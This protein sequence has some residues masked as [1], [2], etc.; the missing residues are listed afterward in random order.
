MRS[1][2]EFTRI[3]C[4]KIRAEVDESIANTIF[5]SVRDVDREI[6]FL[7]AIHNYPRIHVV[8]RSVNSVL[9]PEVRHSNIS[10]III[11]NDLSYMD[12]HYSF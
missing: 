8:M 2:C 6:I 7:L 10:T 1:N 9:S 4:V 5:F 11:V 3:Y 12:S